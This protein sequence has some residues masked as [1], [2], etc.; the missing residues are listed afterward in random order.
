MWVEAERSTG[1]QLIDVNNLG[2]SES[3]R[4][5][6]NLGKEKAVQ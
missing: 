4:F 5:S 2:Q 3:S 6:E 1:R